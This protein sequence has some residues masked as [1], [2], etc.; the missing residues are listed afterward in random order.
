MNSPEPTV[1]LPEGILSSPALL[2]L[3]YR[4]EQILGIRA[5]AEAL[6]K[7][8]AYIEKNCGYAFVENPAAYERVLASREKIFDISKTATI[9]ETYFFREAAHFDLLARH[10]LP[11]LVKLNRPIQICSAATSIGCEAY[12]IAMLLDYYGKNG[13]Q[14][15]FEIDAFDISAEVIETARNARYT[16]NTFRIDGSGWKHVMDLYLVPDGN[17]YVVSQ[18]IREK[19]RFFPHNVM[20]GLEKH[21]DVIFFRNALIYFSPK[22][23]LIVINSLAESLL[24]NGLLFLGTSE[25]SVVR[26]PLLASR[27]F[28]D[29]FYFQ[30]VPGEVHSPSVMPFIEE[31]DVHTQ[32]Q[33]QR[34]TGEDVKGSLATQYPKK[35]AVLGFVQPKRK[36]LS[37]DC[38]EVAAILQTAEGQPNAQK[39]LGIIESEK[40]APDGVTAA[41]PSGDELAA[42]GMHFLGAQDYHSADLVLSHLEKHNSGVLPIFLRGEYHLLLDNTK[43]AMLCFGR[44]AEKEKAF[45]PAFYRLASLSAEE[46]QTRHEYKIKKACESLDLG[47]DFRYECFLGGFSPDYFRRILERK[48]T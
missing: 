32:R 1:E 26:H 42:A 9:N 47:R 20:R 37:I 29:V 19:V 36:E 16:A 27:Y 10:F 28:S 22:N 43:E 40:N 18:D 13:L 6:T 46:N 35:Q 48:L 25:T 11:Q 38:E 30:K 17:E 5:T 15:D 33:I 39:T 14:L 41:S 8:N 24:N 45:W 12:S 4:V 3:Y 34:H 44:A 31:S 2:F 23:R 7:M 21:Y